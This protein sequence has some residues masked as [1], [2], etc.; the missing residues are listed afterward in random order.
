MELSNGSDPAPLENVPAGDM[1]IGISAKGTSDSIATADRMMR[2]KIAP[3][4]TTTVEL[5]GA[6]ELATQPL[7]VTVRCD[8]DV[9]AELLSKDGV[10]TLSL[11]DEEGSREYFAAEGTFDSTFAPS[12]RV[13]L[14][15]RFDAIPPG[16]YLLGGNFPPVAIDV[17]VGTT[18]AHISQR[19]NDCGTVRLHL[20]DGAGPNP[21]SLEWSMDGPRGR[22][23]L[24]MPAVF[25]QSTNEWIVRAPVGS[26]GLFAM[27]ARAGT[28]GQQDLVVAAGET[29]S[30]LKIVWESRVPIRLRDAG[31]PVMPSGDWWESA[32]LT[33]ST[34]APQRSTPYGTSVYGFGNGE[35]YHGHGGDVI[36]LPAP[37]GYEKPAPIRIPEGGF[38]DG[39][40]V[41]I[42]LVRK[43][44]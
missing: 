7:T 24:P 38:P 27:S 44:P 42:D 37:L 20:S 12:G 5:E 6:L 36:Q 19:I 13:K 9:P 14:S 22:P 35:I 43:K 33:T 23:S 29:R 10:S 32:V 28:T 25:D 4:E 21:D 30:D 18:D 16:D 11:A 39:A 15:P 2:V 1:L 40:K 17:H 26:V 31:I 41:T 8:L 3:H 34:G